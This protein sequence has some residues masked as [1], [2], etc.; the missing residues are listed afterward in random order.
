[1]QAPQSIGYA[2]ID[3]DG[4]FAGVEET[5]NP[6]IRGRPIGV[7]P[8]EEQ[9]SS[10]LIAANY[11][12]KARGVKS[13]MSI[14]DARAVCPD[15]CLV[16]Q[17]PDRYTKAH[18]KLIEIIERHIPVQTVC[19]I[20][21]VSVKLDRRD[22]ADPTGLA[23]RIKADIK[24]LCGPWL[25]CSIGFGPNPQLA[26]IASDMDK[27]DGVTFLYPDQLPGRLLDLAL[28]DIPGIAKAMRT[29]L[30]AAGIFTTQDLWD[31]APKQLRAIWRSVEG[32]RFWYALHGFDIPILPTSRSMYGHG[33]VLTPEWRT[34]DRAYDCAHLLTVKAAR[35]MRRD[36]WLAQQFSLYL[37]FRERASWSQSTGLTGG[38]SDTMAAIRALR[39]LWAQA[40]ADITP[41]LQQAR[42]I[43][44]LHVTFYDLHPADKRQLDLFEDQDRQRKRHKAQKLTEAMDM[45]NARAGKSV[46]THGILI[47][48]PGGY[49]GG[50]I[51]FTHVP[52]EQDFE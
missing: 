19:S 17:K 47:E 37:A 26:K 16:P 22:I 51:A 14:S 12:A 44:Q 5:I 40:R 3:F 50:K 2:Y 4:F 48:P 31:S 10:C 11:T 41:S 28:D 29:R 25:T 43:K 42:A 1:M 15:I 46:I 8:F 49:A 23:H 34:M 35:R 24:Q 18:H 38:R 30:M 32:E 27:P 6:A 36:G 21:E 13:I 7:T 33:R 45:L 9:S 52:D 20:D 39:T